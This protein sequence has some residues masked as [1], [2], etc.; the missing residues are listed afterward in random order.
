MDVSAECK[1]GIATV[2]TEMSLVNGLANFFTIGI[3]SPRH[4]TITCASGSAMKP[5]T[6][7]I[8]V[9]KGASRDE[10]SGAVARAVEES[11]RLEQPVVIH[12][13]NR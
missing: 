8:Y 12:F 1:S 3:Y 4:V 13:S 5:G 11:A 9:V 6:L 10:I 2:V 7:N